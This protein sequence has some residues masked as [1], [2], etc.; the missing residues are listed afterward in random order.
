ME[1]R[2]S[3][4]KIQSSHQKDLV[5]PPTAAL[6]QTQKLALKTLQFTIS[7]SF[8]IGKALTVLDAGFALKTHG[9]FVNGFTPFLAGVAGFF[10]SLRFNAPASLKEPFF[11]NS[12][13][14]IAT[15]C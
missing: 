8:F 12:P 11:F 9:S 3:N 14:A 15:P 13:A 1:P 5:S 10:F 4:T 7:F 2:S 6:C